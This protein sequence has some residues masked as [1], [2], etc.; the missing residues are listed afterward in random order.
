MTEFL[1][2]A[3]RLIRPALTARDLRHRASPANQR[4]HARPSG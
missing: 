4:K 2:T 3:L 1:L